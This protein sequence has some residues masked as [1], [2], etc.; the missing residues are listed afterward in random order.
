M[1][2]LAH[3]DLHEGNILVSESADG[4]PATVTAVIDWQ[5]AVV[6]PMFDLPI[7][8]QYEPSTGSSTILIDDGVD[9]P[10][11]Y[12]GEHPR[13]SLVRIRQLERK[14]RETYT[15]RL[16][17]TFP[18][19]YSVTVE[20]RM[21]H[22]R[23][24]TYY[25]SHGWSDGLPALERNLLQLI[26]KYGTTFPPHPDFP[27]CPISFTPE[28]KET[29]DRQYK[30]DVGL[31]E[32]LERKLRKKFDEEE[33]VLFLDSSVA[34]A[35]WERVRVCAEEFYT[36]HSRDL[37]EVPLR[38]WKDRWPLRSDKFDLVADKCK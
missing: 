25:V 9:L 4:G 10:E 32:W 37:P 20:P 24:A 27:S 12:E 19:Y 11:T 6:R 2:S 14:R 33:I 23:D 8:K 36:R 26:E 31:E 17:Q 18:L 16:R 21:K 1:P 13:M 30:L 34:S 38:A 7:P 5:G 28:E 3:P 15:Q 29:T 35:D 22:L